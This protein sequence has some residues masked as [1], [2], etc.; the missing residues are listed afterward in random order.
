MDDESDIRQ[1][2]AKLSIEQLIRVIEFMNKL[3]AQ[4][5]CKTKTN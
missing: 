5:T 1:E 2:L 3:N 4:E